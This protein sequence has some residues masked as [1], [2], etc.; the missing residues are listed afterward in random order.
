MLQSLVFRAFTGAAGIAACVALLSGSAKAADTGLT[1]IRPVIVTGTAAPA[2]PNLFGTVA[3]PI[4]PD[5][6]MDGWERAR[7]DA[8]G[9]PQMQ[10]L[11][12][13]AR[14]LRPEQ[15][16]TYIQGAVFHLIR[17]RSDATEWGQHDYW[18][19]A[20]ET[21]Q[22]GAG[23]ADNRA[24]LKLEALRALGFPTRNLYLTMGRDKVGGPITVLLARVGQRTWVLDDT[25][26]APYPTDSRPEFT[27]ML[28]FGFGGSWI[29]GYAVA[30]RPGSTAIVAAAS[31]ASNLGGRR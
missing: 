8:S 5:R 7:R 21:L 14:N 30:H 6:Y 22:H 20:A 24:I 3:L 31:G 12:A 19:S 1:N 9:L 27:P 13:P 11:I 25:D 16:L 15:Q 23:D 26:G 18:A 28:T 29:H 17:W 4:R 2:P 10:R